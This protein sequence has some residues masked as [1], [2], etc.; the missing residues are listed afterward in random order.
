MVASG[1]QKSTYLIKEPGCSQKIP[2]KLA[3]NKSHC[4]PLW[5]K[6]RRYK[7][8]PPV[9]RRIWSKLTQNP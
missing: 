6:S 9:K 4:F 1:N 2:N 5:L 8:I 7:T 3:T